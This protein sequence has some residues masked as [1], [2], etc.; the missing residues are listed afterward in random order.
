MN[1]AL[2]KDDLCVAAAI[3][4]FDIRVGE[5][6]THLHPPGVSLP[7][8]ADHLAAIAMP[9]GSH[10]VQEDH[11]FLLT[12]GDGEQIFGLCYFHNRRDP[13][14]PRGAIMKSLVLLSRRPFFA[15]FLPVVRAALLRHLDAGDDTVL[16]TLVTRLNE[17]AAQRQAGTL[18]TDTLTIFGQGPFAVAL[19]ATSA[20]DE[21][22]LEAGSL[23]SLV[24]RFREHTMLI[25][26]A[27]LLHVRLLFIGHPCWAV[28]QCCLA[29]PLLVRPLRGFNEGLHPYVPLAPPHLP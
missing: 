28:G 16:A 13:S 22:G 7:I 6:I 4:D 2:R 3:L 14:V 27:L 26:W 24:Q 25:W 1:M 15:F 9:E 12:S 5:G 23:L 20:P 29:A 21:F 18:K 10:K 19:P 8:A 17:L 11:T